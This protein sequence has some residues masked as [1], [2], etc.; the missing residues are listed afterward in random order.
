LSFLLEFSSWVFFS[1]PTKFTKIHQNS[2]N[3]CM[4]LFLKA[5]SPTRTNTRTHWAER[6]RNFLRWSTHADENEALNWDI[7]LATLKIERVRVAIL[8]AVALTAAGQAFGTEF[9][10]PKEQRI[11]RDVFVSFSLVRWGLIMLCVAL[12]E[13]V[14]LL[15]IH[16][17]IVSG[18]LPPQIIRFVSAVV[19]VS[20]VSIVIYTQGPSIHPLY[21][22]HTP[23]LLGYSI[24]I[25]LSTLHLRFW[26][27]VITG[28]SAGIGY[29]WVCWLLLPHR[30]PVTLENYYYTS[31]A[32]QFG[33]A[34]LLAVTGVLAGFVGYQIRVLL[35]QSVDSQREKA[36][37]VGM[38]GQYV[39]PSVVDKLMEQKNT[40]SNDLAGEVRPVTVMFLDIRD[41]TKFSENRAPTEVVAYLNTLFGHLI[42]IVNEHNGIV[43][44]FLGD[45][46]M[47]VFGAPIATDSDPHNAVRAAL[48][49]VEKIESLN[50]ETASQQ[51][52]I[53]IGIHT[54]VAVT[55]SVGSDE[56]KEYTIIGDTVNLASRVEQLTKQFAEPVLLTAA[57]YDR[58]RTELHHCLEHEPLP[59]TQVKGRTEPVT[60]YRLASSV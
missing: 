53:G 46:F 37:I 19:E 41:F 34:A 4:E 40:L 3:V 35:T 56:R 28:L 43:N 17:A 42:S 36:R 15:F 57:V 24:F 29:Y 14:A 20:F 11:L 50:S 18:R 59:P 48:A 27:S 47:A 8:F 5:V 33:R 45:G 10:V 54:G 58:V 52:R 60:V 31:M 51:T 38:F 6:S 21:V 7:A 55:G 12:Y 1:H 26:L 32:V 30:Q 2:P 44:K 39:S 22:V 9:L 23:F 25:I 16:K 49:I 13:G